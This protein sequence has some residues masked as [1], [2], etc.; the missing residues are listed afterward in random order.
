M[1]MYKTISKLRWS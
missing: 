1:K